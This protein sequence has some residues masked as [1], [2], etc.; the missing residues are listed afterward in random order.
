MSLN[1]ET[2]ITYLGHAT[3]L[4]ET[5]KGRHILIDPFTASNP[6]CPD[7][8][9]DPARL[10]KIDFILFT[11]I[12]NDHAQDAAAVIA[13]NPEATVVAGYEVCMWMLTKGAKNISPMNTGGSVTIDGIEFI[14]T[15]AFHSNSFT[16]ED[17]TIVYGGVPGGFVVKFENGFTLYDAGDT[18][19]FGDMKLIKDLYRPDLALLPIGDR[20]T[21]GPRDAA[22]ACR[23]LGVTSVI[24]IHYATFPLLT[25][26]AERFIEHARAI[27][28]LR[29]YALKPGETLR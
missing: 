19:L 9:K 16:E 4:I 21:M 3:L 12:H 2:V 24:P 7:E 14:M 10:G 26:T 27:D 17:G 5:P 20:F 28:G 23:M 6:I 29:V 22:L 8:W 15:L 1:R 25:G 18:S 13:A 11:H